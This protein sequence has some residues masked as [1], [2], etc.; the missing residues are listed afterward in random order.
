MCAYVFLQTKKTELHAT[1]YV[2]C[3]LH[4]F[5]RNFDHLAPLSTEGL[6]E[7]AQPEPQKPFQEGGG[8]DVV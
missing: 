7:S 3:C 2:K 5:N 4:A 6:S 1:I 8:S